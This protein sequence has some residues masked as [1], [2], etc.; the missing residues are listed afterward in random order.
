MWGFLMPGGHH[1]QHTSVHPTPLV[2]TI[3]QML[4][5]KA[6]STPKRSRERRTLRE[7]RKMRCD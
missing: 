4:A 2:I 7:L 6:K 3:E 5:S 1:M